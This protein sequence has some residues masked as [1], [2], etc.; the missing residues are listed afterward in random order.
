MVLTNASFTI[1]KIP[2]DI[3]AIR[4]IIPDIMFNYGFY[5]LKNN[6]TVFGI[7][8]LA[9]FAVILALLIL[10]GVYAIKKRRWAFGWMALY[11]FADVPLLI[12]V[13]NWQAIIVHAVLFAIC[14]YG[15]HICGVRE[16]LEKRM[17]TF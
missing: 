13:R 1:L 4:I 16:Q 10:L 15:V 3:D 7:V 8:L 9:G 11:I 12:L 17:W 6:E 5:A 14:L 2:Y